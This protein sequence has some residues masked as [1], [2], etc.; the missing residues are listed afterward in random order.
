M[1]HASVKSL[2]VPVLPQIIRLANSLLLIMEAAVPPVTTPRIYSRIWEATK[3]EI[4][5]Y[6]FGPESH[7][8][9]SLVTASGAFL[10][11][12]RLIRTPSFG[13][14]EYALVMS[15]RGS[16]VAPSAEGNTRFIG[17]GN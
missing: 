15:S 8:S 16:S 9:I 13:K 5:R 3:G 10:I 7:F 17:L 2:T 6:E 4:T 12:C 14:A 11:R 1:N